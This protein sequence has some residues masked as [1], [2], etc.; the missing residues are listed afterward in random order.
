M[1]PTDRNRNC[2]AH[3]QSLGEIGENKVKAFLSVGKIF[4]TKY[5]FFLGA[6]VFKNEPKSQVF[7][8]EINWF[9]ID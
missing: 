8:N 1:N 7:K 6:V 3:A 9:F 2:V 4:S 5:I